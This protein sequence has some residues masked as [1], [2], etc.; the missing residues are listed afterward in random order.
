MLKVRPKPSKKWR[1]NYHSGNDYCRS[2]VKVEY[3]TGD[4]MKVVGEMFHQLVD[5]DGLQKAEI[6]A[7]CKSYLD[8]HVIEEDV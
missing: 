2:K 1:K 6:L 4:C 3:C 7:L 8:E 5:Y